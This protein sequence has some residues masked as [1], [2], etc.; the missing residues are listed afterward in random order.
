MRKNSSLLLAVLLASPLAA[1]AD[2]PRPA[3]PPAPA[4]APSAPAAGANDVDDADDSDAADVADEDNPFA[5]LEFKAGPQK[6]AMGNEL[7]LDLPAGFAFLD[8]TEAAK[9]IALTKNVT[10]PST[11]GVIIKAD[12]NWWV[13]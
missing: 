12:G 2:K 7:T 11:L 1:R 5:K 8:K 4:T 6:I 13:E 3:K 9:F 10:G